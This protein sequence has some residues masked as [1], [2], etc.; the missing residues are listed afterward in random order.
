MRLHLVCV[1]S[2][3]ILLLPP[4]MVSAQRQG[5]AADV[6]DLDNPPSPQAQQILELTNQARGEQ[7]LGP[8]RWDPA[9]AAA[10]EQHNQLMRSQPQLSHQYSGEEV[11]VS[12][13]G[14]AGA[15]FAS[16][17]ENIAMGPSPAYIQQEWLHS[18]PHRQNIFD[19]RMDAI[20]ISV[21]RR[22][23]DYFAT[24][25]FAQSV[26]SVGSSQAEQEI[27][28]LLR[29]H[30]LSVNTEATAMR[31]ARQTCEMSQ[32]FAGGAQPRFIV[33]WE[34]P[35]LD[36]LPPQLLQRIDTRQARTA[37]VGACTGMHPQTGFTSYRMAVLLF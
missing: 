33:R 30:G 9:L 15:H 3:A 37:V 1:L 16:I 23:S 14:R 24:E 27:A 4:S 32:G 11:L 12:R 13:A 21:I 29:Q 28:G 2:A 26:R 31:E 19:P 34:S 35:T 22:G 25:D 36:Q 8:L 17:A 18:A 6:N 5:V 20:G 10:A 7:G